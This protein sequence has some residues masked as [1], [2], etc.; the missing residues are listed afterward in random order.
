ME[1]TPLLVIFIFALAQLICMIAG[2]WIY[3]AGIKKGIIVCEMVNSDGASATE[4]L[5]QP[6]EVAEHS[7]IEDDSEERKAEQDE[8]E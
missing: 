3:L 2:V 5:G 1:N 4:L 7:L 8:Q 6:R